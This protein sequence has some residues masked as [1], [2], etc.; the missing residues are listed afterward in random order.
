MEESAKPPVQPPA[1]RAIL[2]ETLT[3]EQ[4]AIVDECMKLYGCAYFDQ[5]T[6]TPLSAKEIADMMGEYN[7]LLPEAQEAMKPRFDDILVMKETIKLNKRNRSRGQTRMSHGRTQTGFAPRAA[8]KAK[9]PARSSR[10]SKKCRRSATTAKDT[11]TF[12]MT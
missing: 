5:K 7:K 4:R 1:S 8:A 11:T 6:M 3:A 2:L 12:P 9:P 10:P